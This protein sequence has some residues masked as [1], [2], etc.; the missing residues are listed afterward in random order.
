MEFDNRWLNE[1]VGWQVAKEARQLCRAGAVLE[2]GWEDHRIKGVVM[3]NRKPQLAGFQFGSGGRLDI[4]NLCLCKQSVRDGI[5][6]VHSSAVVVAMIEGGV[7]PLGGASREG[8]EAKAGKGE[9]S[10]REQTTPPVAKHETRDPLRVT[11]NERWVEL[12]EKGRV[13]AKIEVDGEAGDRGLW[14]WMDHR[15]VKQVPAQLVLP[16][17]KASD[18]LSGLK[19]KRGVYWGEREFSVAEVPAS[20]LRVEMENAGGDF[21]LRPLPWG[22]D[23]QQLLVGGTETWVLFAER[24][25]AQAMRVPPRGAEEAYQRLLQGEEVVLGPVDLLRA[26]DQWH[27]CLEFLS[28]PGQGLTLDQARPRFVLSVEGSLHALSGKV[29]VLYPGE[30]SFSLGEEP[31]GGAFPMRPDPEKGEFLLRNPA[32]EQAASRLLTEEWGFS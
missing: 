4:T 6:C 8:I 3:R 32:K 15:G 20:R 29:R 28:P 10:S 9:A 23:E 21:R 26:L 18:L 17:E 5:M 1:A 19:G 30:V 14:S 7:P 27:E 31:P 12:W 2:A 11:F 13:P 25:L 16:P 22:E 24:V